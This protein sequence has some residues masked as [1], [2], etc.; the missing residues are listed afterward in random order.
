VPTSWRYATV[1]IS[2][3]ALP[4]AYDAIEGRARNDIADATGRT[5]DHKP[6]PGVVTLLAV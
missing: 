3:P 1:S 5:G 2:T 6:S 4:A